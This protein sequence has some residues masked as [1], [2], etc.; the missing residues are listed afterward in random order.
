[1]NRIA[2]DPSCHVI[3]LRPAGQHGGMR[4]AAARHGWRLLAL[5]PWRLQARTDADSRAALAA[6]LDCDRVIVTSPAAVS[7]A[8]ALLPLQHATRCTWLAVGEGTRRALQR[9]GVQDVLTPQRMDSEGL[10]DLSPLQAQALARRRVG[11]ITAPEGRGR[12]Q[13]E[14]QA[15]GARLVQADVYDRVPLRPSPQ[16][17]TRLL[18]L[19]P[20][21]WLALSSGQALERLQQTLPADPYAH[22]L[23][24]HVVV[25][26]ARLAELAVATGFRGSVVTAASALPEDL[27]AAI[28]A[29]SSG[30]VCSAASVR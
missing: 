26:S 19:A 27:M 17:V 7:A 22:L 23:Q 24:A 8:D 20:P 5:S 3:S 28:I 18:R 2:A 15:R 10:L 9:H 4:R 29:A 6:A 25:A 12:L 14:L 13:A 11:L 16:A 30:M 21:F 1:M